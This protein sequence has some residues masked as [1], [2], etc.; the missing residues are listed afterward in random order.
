MEVFTGKSTTETANSRLDFT[1]MA[2]GC[3]LD[4]STL[5]RP[6]SS[7]EVANKRVIMVVTHDKQ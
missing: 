7:A 6:I 5:A 2:W 4:K 1:R 3:T